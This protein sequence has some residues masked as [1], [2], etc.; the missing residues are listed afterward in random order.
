MDAKNFVTSSD[1]RSHLS[2][3]KR[4]GLML[5]VRE[6]TQQFLNHHYNPSHALLPPSK[7]SASQAHHG[8]W[9]IND[10][11]MQGLNLNLDLGAAGGYS[12][13]KN[14]NNTLIVDDMG[15]SGVQ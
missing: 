2:P 10:P 1:F 12:N 6:Q 13:R 7:H 15:D 5:A 4:Q 8:P 11:S 14:N 3:K 9:L